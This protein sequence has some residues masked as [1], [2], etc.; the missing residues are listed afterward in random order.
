MITGIY[1]QSSDLN[2]TTGQTII[3]PSEKKE[4][5]QSE[6]HRAYRAIQNVKNEQSIAGPD[7]ALVVDPFN[8]LPI[9]KTQAAKPGLQRSKK[10]LE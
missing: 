8:G 3:L 10:Q 9:K 4:T 5:A 6:P 2:R 1:A 7:Q